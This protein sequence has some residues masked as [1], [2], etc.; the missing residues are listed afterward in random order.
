MFPRMFLHIS[1]KSVSS[2]NSKPRY[3]ILWKVMDVR[4]YKIVTKE[5]KNI[6]VSTNVPPIYMIGKVSCGFLHLQAR[7]WVNNKAKSKDTT[8]IDVQRRGHSW[9]CL[10]QRMKK[11]KYRS[12]RR[13]KKPPT[14]TLTDT[15]SHIIRH[16][17]HR[18]RNLHSKYHTD[19]LLQREI[20]TYIHRKENRTNHQTSRETLTLK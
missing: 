10:R 7:Y 2:S 8:K 1:I 15:Q 20:Q 12:A 18:N 9:P 3:I 16:D 14:I 17:K 6:K 11:T 13:Q 5:V 19:I 4:W